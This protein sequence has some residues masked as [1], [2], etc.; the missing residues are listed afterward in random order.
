MSCGEPQANIA[1][2]GRDV[3][4]GGP[5]NSDRL[6]LTGGTRRPTA[7]SRQLTGEDRSSPTGRPKSPCWVGAV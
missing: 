3:H 1:A 2:G 5:G 4:D 6:P 7:R